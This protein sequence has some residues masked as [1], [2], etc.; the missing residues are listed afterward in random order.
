[1]K[2]KEIQRILNKLLNT[3]YIFVDLCYFQAKE[4]EAE[5]LHRK[6]FN[7]RMIIQ[8]EDTIWEK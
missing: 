2:G 3:E 8:E 7:L 4:S 5:V 1:M 6:K